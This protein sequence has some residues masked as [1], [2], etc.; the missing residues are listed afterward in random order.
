MVY[1]FILQASESLKCQNFQ[2]K[3]TA[4][5]LN[6][7]SELFPTQDWMFGGGG[8]LEQQKIFTDL[9]RGTW[10]DCCWTPRETQARQGTLM[11][12][13]VPSYMHRQPGGVMWLWHIRHDQRSEENCCRKK[14]HDKLFPEESL[15]L[16]QA[17]STV[18]ALGAALY[19]IYVCLYECIYECIHSTRHTAAD[20]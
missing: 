12:Q 7:K 8:A 6:I 19:S 1:I 9:L 3:F 16:D 2:I 13:C 10:T 11:S 14:L 20:K 4:L 5:F 18:S 17:L 15:S